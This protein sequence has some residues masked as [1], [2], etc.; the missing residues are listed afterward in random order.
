MPKYVGG[1]PTIRE[2]REAR[3]LSQP[4]ATGI[5]KVMQTLAEAY[6]KKQQQ[7]RDEEI[8]QKMNNPD[9][10]E[11]DRAQL[12]LKLSPSG[13]KAVM[14]AVQLYQ[15]LAHE[16]AI[17]QRHNEREQRI[18]GQNETKDLQS[19]YLNRLKQIK[20]DLDDF[21]LSRDDKKLLKDQKKALETELGKN[22]NRLRQGKRPVFDVLQVEEEPLPTQQVPVESMSQ[23]GGRQDIPG[24][25]PGF[26]PENS[27]TSYTPNAP[28]NASRNA[29]NLRQQQPQVQ[30]GSVDMTAPTQTQPQKVRWDKNNPEHQAF[31]AKVYQDTGGDRARTNAI[32]AEQFER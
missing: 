5:A 27:G 6:E 30:Q 29:T 18:G 23:L 4:V 10:S 21:S 16:K 26:F 8:V 19:M 1:Y 20:E 31:A 32:L 17:Q 28:Q 7:E 14:T 2:Q 13:Q 12:A 22:L 24:A 9:L 25:T 15:K 11:M 3:G